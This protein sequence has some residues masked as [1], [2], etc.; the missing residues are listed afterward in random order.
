MKST[1][2]VKRDDTTAEGKLE[3]D[4]TFDQNDLPANQ[5]SN[6]QADVEFPVAGRVAMR[7]D[8]EKQSSFN[9]LVL[10]TEAVVRLES[11]ASESEFAEMD[12]TDS[13]GQSWI[14]V[15]INPPGKA[16]MRQ[17]G[18]QGATK[19][20]VE[21]IVTLVDVINGKPQGFMRVTS[22]RPANLRDG[23]RIVTRTAREPQAQ[24][25]NASNNLGFAT[26]RR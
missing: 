23:G 12:H 2:N 14:S 19:I 18:R 26:R 17:A 7:T 11:L 24:A 13:Q 20:V 1:Q 8:G 25:T 21:G 3:Q 15:T 5:S 6:E 4:T 9:L 10:N 16:L 22:A